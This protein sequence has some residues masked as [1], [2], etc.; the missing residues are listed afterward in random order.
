MS[1]GMADRYHT[2]KINQDQLQYLNSPITRREI[3]AVIKIFN[4]KSPGP[5]GVSEEFYQTL[6]ED[7]I[8]IL[9][10]VVHTIETERTLL[11]S[12]YEATVALIHKPH[13]DPT[14][15][16]N[17]RPISLINKWKNTQLNSN[18]PNERPHQIHHS[19]YTF[20]AVVQLKLLVDTVK[21]QWELPLT[22]LPAFGFPSPSW[23][24]CVDLIQTGQDALRP[25]PS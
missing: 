1:V 23:T 20:V 16:E 25:S 21:F 11:T 24:A 12:F 9:V 17:F 13:K 18:Q 6:K 19:P 5:D 14:K 22:L 2:P 8:A 10:R 7:I 15:K 4:Q 3:Q